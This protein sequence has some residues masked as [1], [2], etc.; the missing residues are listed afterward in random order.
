M[1]ISDRRRRFSQLDPAAIIAAETPPVEDS[2]V[3][4]LSLGTPAGLGYFKP[5]VLAG[6]T[7]WL[8]T[9]I[10]DDAFFRKGKVKVRS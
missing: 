6:T 4:V 2:K 5:A 9:K 8:I 3:P 7:V 1:Q 10:L